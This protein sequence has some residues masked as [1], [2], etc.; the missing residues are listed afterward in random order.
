MLISV[1]NAEKIDK[2]GTGC[3]FYQW[4]QS[5]EWDTRE[6]AKTTGEKKMTAGKGVT[7]LCQEF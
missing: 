7:E 3:V 1:E 5:T 4:L 2:I 6:N